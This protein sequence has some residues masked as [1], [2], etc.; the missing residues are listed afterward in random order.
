MKAIRSIQNTI[1]QLMMDLSPIVGSLVIFIML[2]LGPVALA[3]FSGNNSWFLLYIV[4]L[5]AV[6]SYRD[7]ETK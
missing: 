4:T 5:F 3:H 7:P 6:S 2:L 1:H